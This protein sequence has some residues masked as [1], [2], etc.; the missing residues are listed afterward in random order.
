MTVVT[1][2]ISNLIW[3]DLDFLTADIRGFENLRQDTV[4]LPGCQC[5]ERTTTATGPLT[6]ELF[7]MLAYYAEDILCVSKP[8]DIMRSY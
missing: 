1:I 5:D 7:V 6:D 2:E 3:P 4:L 8:S